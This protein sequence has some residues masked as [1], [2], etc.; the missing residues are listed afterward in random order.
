MNPKTN[1]QIDGETILN[2]LID[3]ILPRRCAYCKVPIPKD[4]IVFC[5]GCSDLIKAVPDFG[6]SSL[7]VYAGLLRQFIV[8]AKFKPNESLSRILAR[9]LRQT[10]RKHEEELSFLSRSYS[11]VTYVPSHFRR[12]LIRG[13]ELPALLAKEVAAHL[14]LP[15]VHLLNSTR[16][17]QPLSA[18]PN[19]AARLMKVQDRYK[20]AREMAP[21]V[22]LLVDDVQTSGATLQSAAEVLRNAGHVVSCFAFAQ[23]RL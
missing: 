4:P 8:T 18:E 6:N 10:L 16:Y 13:H 5:D 20:I 9:F 14:K 12:R 7:F 15:L 23:T 21:Q 11:S 17:D 3:A 19:A 22:V 2:S 1:R